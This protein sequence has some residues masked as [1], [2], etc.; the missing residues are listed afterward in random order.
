MMPNTEFEG[1]G[2]DGRDRDS[3][4]KMKG[5]SAN[6]GS[7]A[8]ESGKAGSGSGNDGISQRFLKLVVNLISF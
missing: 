7:K 5:T 2:P 6:T 3:A 1:R 4:K 8:G